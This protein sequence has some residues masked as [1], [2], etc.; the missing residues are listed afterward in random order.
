MVGNV[1]I[2][3]VYMA[4]FTI[5]TKYFKDIFF[6]SHLNI[7]VLPSNTSSSLKY[8]SFIIIILLYKGI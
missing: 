4:F 3:A 5:F 6:M 8:A 7:L 2:I 1:I